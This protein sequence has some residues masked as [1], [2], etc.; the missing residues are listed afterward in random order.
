M[1]LRLQEVEQKRKLIQA[2]SSVELVSS[3]LSTRDIKKL[4]LSVLPAE[5]MLVTPDKSTPLSTEGVVEKVLSPPPSPT[6][7]E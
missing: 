3:N 2:I 5:K 7:G 4:D 1:T 6:S